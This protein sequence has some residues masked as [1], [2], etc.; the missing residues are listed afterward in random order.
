MRPRSTRGEKERERISSRGWAKE[1]GGGRCTGSIHAT[2]VQSAEGASSQSLIGRWRVRTAEH[3]Y[4][5][6][7]EAATCYRTRQCAT[8]C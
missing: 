4:S 1:N 7:T 8:L 5:L 3:Y 6:T 2:D